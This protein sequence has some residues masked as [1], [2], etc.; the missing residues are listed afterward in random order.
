MNIHWVHSLT[1]ILS[2]DKMKFPLFIYIKPPDDC[3][4][5]DIVPTGKNLCTADDK[6]YRIFFAFYG[7]YLRTR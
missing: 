7:Q 6:P 5:Q 1:D 4:L 2:F 3:I